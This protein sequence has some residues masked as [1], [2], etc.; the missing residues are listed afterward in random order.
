[1]KL[2][3]II[4]VIE[5]YAPPGFQ[6]SYDN[7]GLQ[8]GDH[9]NEIN[10]V[11]LT[12]DVT[13]E[14]VDEAIQKKA[15]MILAHHPL[16]FSPLKRV[17]GKT[18]TERC[19]AK[20]IKNDIALYAA[21]TN[22][23]SVKK[24]V[25]AKIC[26][27]LELIDCKVLS[28]AEGELCKLVTF[29]PS[30]Y[31][32]QVRMAIF[33]AGAGAIGEYDWCSYNLEGTGTFRGSESTNPFVGEKGKLHFEKETRIETIFPSYLKKKVIGAMIK[34]HPYEEVA[35]DIYPLLNEYG[36][37]GMGMTGNTP[38]P[39][40]A[41]DFID[42]IKEIFDCQVVRHTAFTGKQINK[43][44]VCGGSG[45]FLIPKAIAANADIFITGEIRYHQFFEAEGKI[46]L[47]DIGHFESEQFTKEIFYELLTKNFPKFALHF[48]EINTNPIK[49]D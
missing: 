32:E 46:I 7:S 27:K 17:T 21:H 16:I 24:G 2:Q 49:Y 47:A 18:Y 31:A 11:L 13:E 9:N 35:Y 48:S 1:M 33:S 23:D 38:E 3:E 43:V 42:R 34:A 39:V 45:A 14:V 28:P 10:T 29:V 6:E 30:D 36:L 20:L 15:D 19:V 5:S 12:I 26:E 8:V 41:V 44:A 22:L 25:N 37:V 4:S 40:N